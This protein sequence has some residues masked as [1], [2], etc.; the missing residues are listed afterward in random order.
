MK[1]MSDLGNFLC[2]DTDILND[3][4]KWSADVETFEKVLTS[5]VDDKTK[6]ADDKALMAVFT[7]EQRKVVEEYYKGFAIDTYSELNGTVQLQIAQKEAKVK[8]RMKEMEEELGCVIKPD[9]WAYDGFKDLVDK[10]VSCN[11]CKGNSSTLR[12][13][14]YAVNK[15][16]GISLRFGCDCAANFFSTSPETFSTIKSLQSKLLRDIKVIACICDEMRAGKTQILAHYYRYKGRFV[17]RLLVKDGNVLSPAESIA[18]LENILTFK[19][20]TT[21]DGKTLNGDD[22]KGYL[23]T[24][25]GRQPILK[26]ADWVKEHIVY[27][28][29]ADLDDNFSKPLS[30]RK[31]IMVDSKPNIKNDTTLY[32]LT[33]IKFLKVGLPIPQ[34]ICDKINA[35]AAAATRNHHPDY[36]RFAM[37]LLLHKNLA[38]TS[39]LRTAFT[40]F[41][42][43]YITTKDNPTMRDEE[44]KKWGIS[45]IK[46]YYNT[47]LNWEAFIN[48]LKTLKVCEKLIRDNYIAE[49]RLHLCLYRN[50]KLSNSNIPYFVTNSNTARQFVQQCIKLFLTNAEVVRDDSALSQRLSKYSIKDLDI[51]ISLGDS[52][53][54]VFIDAA[55]APYHL[56]VIYKMYEAA[57][58]H[59]IYDDISNAIAILRLIR[60]SKTPEELIKLILGLTANN[61][62][63]LTIR[64]RVN[65]TSSNVNVVIDRLLEQ[66][67]DAKTFDGNVAT[68]MAKS[69]F[70]SELKQF[71]S[72]ANH[73]LDELLVV[74]EHIRGLKLCNLQ[75]R[76]IQ[77][78]NEKLFGVSETD[79]GKPVQLPKSAIDY[80]MDYCNMLTNKPGTETIVNCVNGAGIKPLYAYKGMVESKPLF[81]DIDSV[82]SDLRFYKML[83]CFEDEYGLIAVFEKLIDKLT[84]YTN[85][86]YSWIVKDKRSDVI[87]DKDTDKFTIA[88][89]DKFDNTLRVALTAPLYH[90]G[91]D[92]A[93]DEIRALVVN[94]YNE[95]R[96]ILDD[97]KARVGVNKIFGR[98]VSFFGSE[99]ITKKKLSNVASITELI[100]IISPKVQS[101][102]DFSDMRRER[103]DVLKSNY[104][105]DYFN[106]MPYLNLEAK[107]IDVVHNAL[108]IAYNDYMVNNAAR[109][110]LEA[111]HAKKQPLVDRITKTAEEHIAFLETEVTDVMRAR[112]PYIKNDTEILRKELFT[113]TKFEVG[114]E[115]LVHFYNTLLEM[116]F[117]D[118]CAKYMTM[119][120]GVISKGEVMSAQNLNALAEALCTELYNQNLIYNHFKGITPKLLGLLKNMDL[121]AMAEDDLIIVADR[122]GIYYLT[123]TDMYKICEVID[124]YNKDS[125][126]VDELQAAYKSMALPNVI[127]LDERYNRFSDLPDSTGLTGVEKA[128]K[129]LAHADVGTLPDTLVKTCKTVKKYQACS[130]KQLPYVNDAFEALK[131]GKVDR[132]TDMAQVVNGSE[133]EGVKLAKEVAANPNFATLPEKNRDIINSVITKNSCSSKQLY[134]VK[135]SA[136]QLSD[137]DTKDNVADKSSVDT[138][139]VDANVELAKKVKAHTDFNTLPVYVRNIVASVARTGKC[140]DKQLNYVKQGADKL[141]IVD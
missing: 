114:L 26:D 53:I 61:V 20:E 59:I 105:F 19:L 29:N 9:E 67:Y 125:H 15:K 92:G 95:Y 4:D 1:G 88:A 81:V 121:Y 93:A 136:A 86:V 141:G 124:K 55:Y 41:M 134:W 115:K 5:I 24:Y 116:G 38:K 30:A 76:D 122:V 119:A 126:A 80:Y 110:A 127:S 46:S 17:G 11:F 16:R 74:E 82:C 133:D 65:S 70:M 45:G 50:M 84:C 37:E 12:Y 58:Q 107:Y 71:K 54:G 66:Y 104:I 68:L 102:V 27:C 137:T 35:K 118:E 52:K 94:K 96:S 123:Y 6:Y 99:G 90:T 106:F 100:S 56:A 131:L 97:I 33:A 3:S 87:G 60:Y 57:L 28:V 13:V 120:E 36:M 128:E 49:D 101:Y 32:V 132:P 48:R 42:V 140:S 111:E 64:R 10:R 51:H 112:H 8:Q 25:R 89:V 85:V 23:V 47:V 31:I 138:A 22:T 44:L 139:T 14:H 113:V 39:L 98:L 130:K 73:L 7:P 108:S 40:E 109:L 43:N 69:E 83:D 135:R 103:L 63:P 91:A 62:K 77:E 75:I 129:V 2:V 21:Q 34:S 78:E 18:A 72:A 117:S 79:D